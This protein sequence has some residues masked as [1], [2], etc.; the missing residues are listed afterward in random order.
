MKN[1]TIHFLFCAQLSLILLTSNYSQSQ[2]IVPLAN[3]NKWYYLEAD[4]AFDAAGLG[5]YTMKHYIVIKT[6]IRDTTI[7]WGGSINGKLVQI[8]AIDQSN[9]RMNTVLDFW[10]NDSGSFSM[11]GTPTYYNG[12]W[13]GGYRKY[14]DS[15]ITK[16]T[17][18]YTIPGGSEVTHVTN[19]IANFHGLEL[20]SQTWELTYKVF[21]WRT[22]TA[23]G[24]GI[25]QDTLFEEDEW[26]GTLRS[27]TNLVGA[28]INGKLIGD[29]IPLPHLAPQ[30][31]QNLIGERGD[32]RI[33]LK[34]SKNYE[35]DVERYRLYAD[36]TCGNLS[37]FD[38]TQS[39]LDTV[40][41]FLH[42]TNGRQYR[43][44]LTAVDSFGYESQL[45]A[46]VTITPIVSQTKQIIVP[47]Q[48]G[49]KWFYNGSSQTLTSGG[50]FYFITTKEVIGDTVIDS[51]NWKTIRVTVSDTNS[52]VQSTYC[53]YYFSD[54]AQLKAYGI[55]DHNWGDVSWVKY[56]IQLYD[57][58]LINDTSW[59]G[60]LGTDLAVHIG[61]SNFAG[62]VFRSQT[63]GYN[64]P[65]SSSYINFATQGF[66]TTELGIGIVEYAWVAAPIA[67]SSGNST[68][69]NLVAALINGRLLGDSTITAINEQATNSTILPSEYR[70][71]QNYPN[72]FNPT[73]VI[74]YQLATNSLVLLKIYNI[75]GEEVS[76]LINARQN[77]GY[78]TATFNA[79]SLPSGVYFYRL[80]AGTYS[81]T[82]KLLLL[83]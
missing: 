10:W 40:I 65:G 53:E 33:Q 21:D 31:P 61:Q 74:G 11:Q 55:A 22:T 64:E 12:G 25:L 52:V 56:P 78:Y 81:S 59:Y 71:E 39:Q 47:L 79:R 63:F 60:G 24:L 1:N 5:T 70:L 44:A 41:T 46:L 62:N 36:S 49:N 14:Y 9:G 15:T 57:S 73:T 35:S 51:A 26:G 13:E 50:H 42:L 58:S 34:W 23:E 28:I 6:I 68:V 37:L 76:T 20:K 72:P 3:G 69:N 54:S 75:L 77:A 80:Q 7:Y 18:W 2:E 27:S 32:T 30:S 8:Q 16:E 45:S 48:I 29:S 17:Y 4:T 67:G 82:K 19:G 66:W 43:F 38:S 83:K